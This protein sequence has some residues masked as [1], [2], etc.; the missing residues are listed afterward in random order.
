MFAILPFSIIRDCA[1]KPWLPQRMAHGSMVIISTGCR[2]LIKNLLIATQDTSINLYMHCWLTYEP[3]ARLAII[4]SWNIAGDAEFACHAID[5]KSFEAFKLLLQKNKG[6]ESRG[7]LESRPRLTTKPG[8][9][10]SQNGASHEFSEVSDFLPIWHLGTKSCPIIP[11]FLENISF[12]ESS[13]E[14]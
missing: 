12:H 13:M 4:H 11:R 5:R 14:M 6:E 9:E 10:W 7:R 8:D 3:F 2:D 1:K